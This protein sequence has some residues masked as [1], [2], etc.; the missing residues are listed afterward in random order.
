MTEEMDH[1]RCSE[2]LVAYMRDELNPPE[3]AEVDHHLSTCLDCKAEHDA[4]AGLLAGGVPPLRD[5]ERRV[6]RRAVWAEVRPSSPSVIPLRRRGERVAQLLGAAALIAVLVT[7]FFYV[8]GTGGDDLGGDG[9]T[10]GLAESQDA[11]GGGE[12]AAKRASEKDEAQVRENKS[13]AA[14][15]SRDAVMA[16][17]TFDPSAPVNDEELRDVAGTKLF[18]SFSAYDDSDTPRARTRLTSDLARQAPD[19]LSA[20]VKL[21]A[22]RVYDTSSRRALPVYG[23]VGKLDS[24]RVLILGFAHSKAAGGPLDRFM[25]WAWPR[26]ECRPVVDYEEGPIPDG[27]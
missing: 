1:D 4:L 24:R 6:L 19:K 21:C 14:Q 3:R 7:G 26:G 22:E 9:G 5:E 20:Q 17:P 11:A 15:F 27:P 18:K 23:T 2:L 8:A 25:F 12:T 10:A 16:R 13:A